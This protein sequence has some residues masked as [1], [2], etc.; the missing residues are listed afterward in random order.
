MCAVSTV[1]LC[2][3][4]QADGNVWVNDGNVEPNLGF[5]ENKTDTSVMMQLSI[6]HF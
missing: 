4:K 2:F 3:V 6:V 5:A 1:T